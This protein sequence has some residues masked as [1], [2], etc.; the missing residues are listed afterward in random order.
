ME[1]SMAKP[2]KPFN[3]DQPAEMPDEARRRDQPL[4]DAPATVP[5]ASEGIAPGGTQPPEDGGVGQHPI[6]DSDTED[7]G[8]EDY[9]ELTDE[10]ESTGIKSD[11]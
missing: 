6:H 1:A 8:P 11:S 3:P 2:R 5:K 10:V 7:L 4:A 9:E